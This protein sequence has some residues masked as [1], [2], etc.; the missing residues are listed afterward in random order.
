MN[1]QA[2]VT[3]NGLISSLIGPFAGLVNDWA[4]WRRSGCEEVLRAT[5]QGRDIL[6]IYGDLA[7]SNAYR[8]SCPFEHPRGRRFLPQDKKDFN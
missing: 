1:W 8:I 6:Y 2:I 7:Y 5:F 4:I 3:P